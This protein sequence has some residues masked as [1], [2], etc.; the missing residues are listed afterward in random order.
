M[1]L[2]SADR[3]TLYGVGLQLLRVLSQF[4]V[5][6]L[7]YGVFV[8]L[9]YISTSAILRRTLKCRTIW[10]VS[11]FMITF[12]T[13]LIATLYWAAQ[14]ADFAI[15]I[16]M[17][18]MDNLGLPLDAAIDLV[19]GGLYQPN[20]II[21]WT[22]QLLPTF[23][24][25]VVIWRAWVIFPER[26]WV[27]ICPLLLLLGNIVTGFW[28]LGLVTSPAGFT[29]AETNSSQVISKL[30][31]ANL[32][33]SMTSNAVVTLLIA[34]KLWVHRRSLSA[35]GVG[36][37]KTFA[38]KVLILLVE[39][40]VIYFILQLATLLLDVLPDSQPQGS[41]SDFG[42]EVFFACYIMFAAMYPTIVVILVNTH[43]SVAETF[44]ISSGSPYQEDRAHN[45]ET[46]PAT[47]GHLSFALHPPEST[48]DTSHTTGDEGADNFGR[49][50]MVEKDASNKSNLIV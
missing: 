31:A 44:A 30:L 34:Y 37:K 10:A 35:I 19:D 12:L 29:A 39:S 9:F 16:R 13:F 46:R 24:D 11:R 6:T 8:V 17:P 1:S 23:S 49:G 47:F 27:M 5:I 2:D 28:Y 20:L 32:A 33:L 3:E 48:T 7:L 15:F 43:H 36:N 21:L 42:V 18:L 38:Q 4:T 50:C 14:V 45:N 41:A 25:M 26:R 40:G 22:S